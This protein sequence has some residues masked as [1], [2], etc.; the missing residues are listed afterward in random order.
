MNIFNN[1]IMIGLCLAIIDIISMSVTK[2]V[3]LGFL[4][5]KWMVFAF[6]LYGC[7]ILIFKHG[8]ESTSMSVL[9][10]SWNLLSNIVITLIGI[11]YFQEKI[12]NLESYGILFALFSLFLF[13]LNE[14]KK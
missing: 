13:G 7:Q 5:N 14:Y 11:F 2:Q 6:I 3:T 4:Q 8:L 12:N 9:N 10:L 1:A